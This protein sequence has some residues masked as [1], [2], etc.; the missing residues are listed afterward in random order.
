MIGDNVN[1]TVKRYTDIEKVKASRLACRSIVIT[2]SIA[3]G[4]ILV[5]VSVVLAKKF[6]GK[7]A[8]PPSS[9]L[10]NDEDYLTY[11]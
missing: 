1:K 9:S 2:V 4:I 6:S 8:S 11:L 5:S 7:N 10:V 3:M